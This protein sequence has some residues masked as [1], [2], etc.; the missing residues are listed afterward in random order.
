MT[1]LQFA[2]TESATSAPQREIYPID[3]AC[4]KLGNVSRASIYRWAAQGKIR[5]VKIGGRTFISGAEIARLS[6]GDEPAKAA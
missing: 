5:L 4:T 2:R 1:T 6:R 3:E